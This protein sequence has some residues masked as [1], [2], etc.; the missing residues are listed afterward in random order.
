MLRRFP[1]LFWL[2]ALICVGLG[3]RIAYAQQQCYAFMCADPETGVSPEACST[4]AASLQDQNGFFAYGGNTVT[5]DVGT[6]GGTPTGPGQTCN[7]H[8]A[9]CGTNG[10]CSQ[11]NPTYGFSVAVSCPNNCSHL[12]N[13][14][15]L[16][17][18]A[19]SSGSTQGNGASGGSGYCVAGCEY[20]N[21]N[22]TLV[23]GSSTNTLAGMATPSGSSCGSTDSTAMAGNNCYTK[24]GQ[25]TC[26][27]DSQNA[28]TINGDFIQPSTAPASGSCVAFASGGV[29][30]TVPAS[31]NV[32]PGATPAQVATAMTGNTPPGPDNGTAGTPATPTLVVQ[33]GGKTVAYYSAATVNGSTGVVPSS[34]S[35]GLP[36]GLTASGVAS[37]TGTAPDDCGASGVNCQGTLPS[38]TRTDTVQSAIQTVITGIENSPI[39][40]EASSIGTG[41][42]SGSCPSGTVVLGYLHT[43]VDF[44]ATMCG[45]FNNVLP[46]MQQYMSA[47]WAVICVFI[48]LS[49]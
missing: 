20:T 30:C 34:S 47:I 23:I 7:L 18:I 11:Q 29:M 45:I 48:V 28:A 19:A 12:P 5:A 4:A 37:G 41:I 40:T 14:D 21:G 26:A 35:N 39:Y 1:P 13:L 27:V 32:T 17:T 43:T 2:L 44:T 8:L 46:T 25:T 15:L 3:A 38:L 9:I 24:A 10:V 16:S 36:G 42:G 22:N 33:S 49:A 6:C 31:S